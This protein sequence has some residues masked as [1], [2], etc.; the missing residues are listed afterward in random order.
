MCPLSNLR[1][2]GIPSLDT[3]PVKRSLD[4]GLLVTVNSDDPSYFG[5]YVNDNYLGI[6]HALNLSPADLVKLAK[7]SFIASF[8]DDAAKQSGIDAVD[9]Y[10]DQFKS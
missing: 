7:N 4:T 5:G 3:S 2:K 8:V 9:A 6:Y 1:L 10:V